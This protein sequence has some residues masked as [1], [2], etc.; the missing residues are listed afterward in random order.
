MSENGGQTTERELDAEATARR[1]IALARI[2]QY[3]DPVLRMRAKEVEQFDDELRRLA[4][5]M[6]ALMRDAQ[7]VGIA[8]NQV[9]VVR[10]VLIV[11][12]DTDA[13]PI[14]LVNP[15]VTE[16][17][18]ERETLEEGCLS[19]RGVHVPVERPTCITVEAQDLDGEPVRLQLEEPGARVLQHEVDHLDGVL[20]LDRTTPE[21]RRDALGTL[22]P[23][24]VLR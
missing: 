3:G 6:T 2:R 11:Q 15:R 17:G 8:G 23:Q 1:R 12:P 20:I 19:L 21:A 16:T 4:E 9:G 13:D 18:P 24:P 22:R 14:P 5:R 10:R 7:G